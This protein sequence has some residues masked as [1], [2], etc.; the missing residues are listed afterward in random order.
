M[1]ALEPLPKLITEVITRFH[2]FTIA[3]KI[4]RSPET[5]ARALLE[6]G[7]AMVLMNR[8]ETMGSTYGEYVLLDAQGST[9]LTGGK[10][11]IAHGIFC[12]LTA[13][14][15]PVHEPERD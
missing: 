11:E 12:K 9:I 15:D 10:E 7:V 1:L 2:P 4:D 13:I 8:P 5:G 6:Q 3:F 14:P